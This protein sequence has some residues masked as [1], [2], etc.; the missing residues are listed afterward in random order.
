MIYRELERLHRFDRPILLPV[1]RKT[2]IGDVLAVPALARD[3]G[4][5]ACISSATTRGAP[6]LPV[7]TEKPAAHV[8]RMPRVRPLPP[9]GS[10]VSP[11][12]TSSSPH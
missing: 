8:Y 12:Q 9:T 10:Y 7:H 6:T 3:A 2:V 1:S 11:L 4:T 5:L